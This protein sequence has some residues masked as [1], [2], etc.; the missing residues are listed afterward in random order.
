M[1]WAGPR[2]WRRK[3]V[4]AETEE[5]RPGEAIGLHGPVVRLQDAP[6]D[7][8]EQDDVVGVLPQVVALLL[9]RANLDPAPPSRQ[10]RRRD[11][12]PDDHGAAGQEQQRDDAEKQGH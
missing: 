10:P 7:V 2:L 1:R 12:P 5:L 3:V 9:A 4:E 11:S 8:S 6:L